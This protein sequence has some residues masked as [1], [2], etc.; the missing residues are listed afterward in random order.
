[1]NRMQGITRLSFVIGRR[2]RTLLF[3]LFLLPLSTLAQFNTNRLMM[4]GRIALQYEDYVLSIQYFNRVI[5]LKPYLYEPWQLRAV[6][7]FYL[8]DFVGAE[9]DATKAIS[10]N[11]YIDNLFD[12]RAI[13]RIRQ[14]NYK[15]AISDYDQAIRINPSIM[16]YWYNRAL[17]Y[18]NEKDYDKALQQTD[19]VIGKWN[20]NASAYS[21]KA[22]I[23]L[24]KKDTTQAAEWL[25]KSLTL[26]PYNANAWTMRAYIA[27]NK[28]QW[29]QADKCLT[30]AIRLKPTEVNNYVTRALARINL[31]NLRGVMADYDKAIELDPDNFLAHYNRGLIRVQLGDD[32]RAVE[33]F[34]FVIRMEPSNWMAIY[35][36]AVLLDRIGDLRGAIRDYTTVINQFPNFWTGLQQRA[37]CYRRLG[38]TAKAE[39]D[40]FRIFK[41]QMDK[42]IGIQQRWSR[43]KLRNVRKR[44]EINL[45]KYNEIVVED[46]PTVD[47]EYNSAYRGHVQNKRVEADI[48][49]MYL[50][51]YT[52]YD[53]G[54]RSYQAFD[55]DVEMFNA[56]AHPLHEIY[57]NCN[58]APM[59]SSR[60][61]RYF[62][63]IDSLT[64]RLD[65]TSTTAQINGSLRNG[66]LS[67]LLQRAVA[68][69]TVQNYDAALADLDTYVSIDSTSSL[70][71]WQ[72]AVSLYQIYRYGQSKDTEGQLRISLI[73]DNFQH[74][75]AR[76]RQNAYLYYDYANF[77]FSQKDYG[78][79][80]DYYGKAIALDSKLAEAYYNRGM[81]RILM[82]Q[83]KEGIADLSKAGELGLY[84]A[85]S[86]IKRYSKDK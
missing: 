44:S 82:N 77:C 65:A 45:D 10:L 26:D 3:V 67:L 41:A 12:L 9:Q 2:V 38:M 63:L 14:G 27:V 81:T 72:R 43:S 19:S 4:S 51:S 66:V 37:S 60:I 59:D 61:H 5:S 68:Y 53:N 55:K 36:R 31:N 7:K 40:E 75:I 70:A 69:S 48:L 13:S 83:R 22:E 47:H 42:H 24:N 56:S 84:D 80:A 6:A 35:N 11:P 21:L 62:V 18:F 74:A 28:K 15:E 49:P 50:L 85:Y 64:L 8:D 20:K 73:K 23:F 25:D 54:V 29:K 52:M 76:N 16:G 86:V 1:M 58:A 17:C 78:E 71:F 79:A 57:V 32:N 39:L 33:D 46:E 34:N 30:E